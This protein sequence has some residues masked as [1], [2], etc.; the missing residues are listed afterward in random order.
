MINEPRTAELGKNKERNINVKE[1]GC[2]NDDVIQVGFGINRRW[3]GEMTS[4][5][6]SR[7]DNRSRKCVSWGLKDVEE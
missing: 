7:G 1:G 4:G 6:Y 5:Q 3:K 2:S